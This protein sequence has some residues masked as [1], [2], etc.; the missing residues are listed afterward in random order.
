MKT[1]R[2][3]KI[4]TIIMILGFGFFFTTKLWG[5][6]DRPFNNTYTTMDLYNS[7][8]L[9]RVEDVVYMSQIN[10]LDI[11]IETTY[12]N[13]IDS[14]YELIPVIHNLDGSKYD[15]QLDRWTWSDN[16]NKTRAVYRIQLENNTEDEK[17]NWYYA[18]LF[19]LDPTDQSQ[20]SVTMDYRKVTTTEQIMTS[21]DY[22]IAYENPS[23]S[24]FNSIIDE[25]ISNEI[26]ES[27]EQLPVTESPT[28]GIEEVENI[29][30]SKE[31]LQQ[32]L[33]LKL[34][35]FE[36]LKQD[37]E[38]NPNDMRLQDLVKQYQEEISTL[39][40]KISEQ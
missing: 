12:L 18:E 35:E 33:D 10:A 39:E 20:K 31:E 3:Y 16:G 8:A 28:T 36:R 14:K 40:K 17:E 34:E 38:S 21:D 37:A 9:V 24:I 22:N 19:L 15:A 6:D 27:E 30:Y 13:G 26:I 25:S 4:V 5:E 23:P 2:V 1:N 29:T 11:V 7:Q 32:Q